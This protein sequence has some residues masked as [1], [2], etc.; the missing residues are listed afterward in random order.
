MDNLSQSRVDDVQDLVD[1][2]VVPVDTIRVPVLVVLLEVVLN[3]TIP[4]PKDLGNVH[5]S[6]ACKSILNMFHYI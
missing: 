1:A 5:R 6:D 3:E 4:L 2:S